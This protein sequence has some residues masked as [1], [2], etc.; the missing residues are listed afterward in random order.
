MTKAAQQSTRFSLSPLQLW[1]LSAAG[2]DVPS[3]ANAP[4]P[5]ALLLNVVVVAC[6]GATAAPFPCGQ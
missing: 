6:T 1:G 5:F 3:A 4:H 2:S